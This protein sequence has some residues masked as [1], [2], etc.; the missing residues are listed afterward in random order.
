[1]QKIIDE[2]FEPFSDLI[3]EWEYTSPQIKA[4]LANALIKVLGGL[5]MNHVSGETYVVYK[6]DIQHTIELIKQKGGI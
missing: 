2:V 4:E 3:E 5:P 1:M 6:S